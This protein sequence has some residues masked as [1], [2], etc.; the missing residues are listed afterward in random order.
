VATL[1]QKALLPAMVLTGVGVALAAAVLA[2][3]V[4]RVVKTREDLRP[5][6]AWLRHPETWACL[7]FSAVL[8]RHM[9]IW[10]IIGWDGRSIW[11]YR[12]KQLAYN[13]FL[14]IADA[15]NPENFFS[16]MEYPLLFPSWLAHFATAGPVREREIA[17]G[18]M[19]L[20]LALLACLW[21][22]ARRRLGR[23][24]GAA[25]VGAVLV[26]TGGI[27]E[28]GYADG[29]LTQFLLIL[30]FALDDPA[31]E[32]YGWLAALGAALTKREGLMY[33]GACA[34][35]FVV[36]HPRFR[37]KR[38]LPRLAPALV[39]LIPVAHVLWTK[40]I[41]I[42]DTHAGAKLPATA[43]LVFERLGIIWN[44]IASLAR[45][46]NPLAHG[47]AALGAY[48]V[49]EYVG[50]R[51]WQARIMVATAVAVV[52]FAYLA[53]LVTPYDLAWQVNT[54]MERL[55][56]HAVFAVMAAVLVALTARE[57]AL[58]AQNVKS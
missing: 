7:L 57:S 43:A 22:L 50:R 16:H 41:G 1:A 13:G 39:F 2:L 6:L 31:L 26:V 14:T 8:V 48:A 45:G 46:S 11:L 21:W 58:P 4:R 20:Q 42:K 19:L 38:W 9:S 5:R 25:F 49:L 36:F 18:T 56:L 12:A 54:A 24:V 53:M 51:S 33:A 28:R 27:V 17:V 44:G 10:P 23:W 40:A 3:G 15:V 34:A 29:L 35:L 32:R 30:M 37:A 52:V 47:F 55:L